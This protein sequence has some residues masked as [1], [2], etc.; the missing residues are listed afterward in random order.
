[1]RHRVVSRSVFEQGTSRRQVPSLGPC[2]FKT[3]GLLLCDGLWLDNNQ[4]QTNGTSMISNH[5]TP[6]ICVGAVLRDG[7]SLP[8]GLPV[9]QLSGVH[10]D[11][12]QLIPSTDPQTGNGDRLAFSFR[13]RRLHWELGSPGSCSSRRFSSPPYE[14]QISQLACSERCKR[15][16]RAIPSTVRDRPSPRPSSENAGGC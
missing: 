9:V 5:D 8:R 7:R 1:L 2:P 4:C 3:A 11:E 12:W 10:L 6:Q 14:V 13:P 15:R 16:S